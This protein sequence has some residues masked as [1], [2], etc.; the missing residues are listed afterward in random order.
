MNKKRAYIIFLIFEI[1]AFVSLFTPIYQVVE[2]DPET[3]KAY[4]SMF[5]DCFNH[6][7]GNIVY[8]SYI[9]F[10]VTLLGVAFGIFLMVKSLLVKD[11][12]S[13]KEDKFFIFGCF[14][15]AISYAFFCLMTLGIQAFI[16][17]AL[18]L[19]Y[20]ILTAVMIVVHHRFLT[21]Y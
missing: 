4:L 13:D 10:A 12:S 9:F 11:K 20:A 7:E 14:A 8:A 2:G 5:F 3:G 21:D 15:S 19:L 18:S 16:P 17:M 6:Q 1:L